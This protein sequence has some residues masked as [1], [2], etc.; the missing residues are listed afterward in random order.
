MKPCY[1]ELNTKAYPKINPTGG[2][3]ITAGGTGNGAK[4]SE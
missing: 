3:S 1:R 4:Q 2:I